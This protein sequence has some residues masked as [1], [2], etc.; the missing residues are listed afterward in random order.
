MYK[1]IYNEYKC[2]FVY[3]DG[4]FFRKYLIFYR[5]IE[6][7]NVEVMVNFLVIGY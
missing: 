5:I 7:N 6:Y 3:R 4:Y 1:Y 2:V